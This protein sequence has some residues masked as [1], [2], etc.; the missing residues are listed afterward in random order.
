M[1]MASKEEAKPMIMEMRVP[2]MT[3]A[4]TSRPRSSVPKG[5]AAEGACKISLP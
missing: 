5:W 3:W 1:M 4:R 2:Q